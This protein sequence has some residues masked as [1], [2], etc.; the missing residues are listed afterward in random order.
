M[1]TRLWMPCLARSVQI[2]IIFPPWLLCMSLREP[3][4]SLSLPLTCLL[5][6]KS[7]KKN[8]KILKS[9]KTPPKVALPSKRMAKS[10]FRA[11]CRHCWSPYG[12]SCGPQ[13]ALSKS[14]DSKDNLWKPAF[15]TRNPPVFGA[16]HLNL[17]DVLFDYKPRPSPTLTQMR[18]WNT[19]V[20]SVYTDPRREFQYG[21]YEHLGKLPSTHFVA[22]TC[23]PS[24]AEFSAVIRSRW[25]SSAPGPNSIPYTICK[26]CPNLQMRLYSELALPRTWKI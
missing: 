20:N 15:N 3:S 5:P 22:S 6:Q 19:S 18:Q 16:T 1:L 13:T 12:I 7:R 2:S 10:F 11:C 25:N 23:S 21:P 4:L 8:Q 9:Q 26:R 17:D 24:F 14:L